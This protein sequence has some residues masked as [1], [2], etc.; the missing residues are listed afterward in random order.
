MSSSL[1]TNHTGHLWKEAT[2]PPRKHILV[3]DDEPGIRL[4]LSQVLSRAGYLVDVADDG[5]DAWGSI[6]KTWYDAFILDLK[7]PGSD[8]RELYQLM[9]K[10]DERMARRVI[11]ITG[12]TVTQHTKVFLEETGNLLVEKPF[13]INELQRRLLSL[14]QAE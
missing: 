3:V 8:G 6:S 12:D 1:S 11:F 2:A 14:F 13:D 10:T 9:K 4:L 7:M 5:Y